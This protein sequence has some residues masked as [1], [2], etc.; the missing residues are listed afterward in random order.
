MMWHD[1]LNLTK[2]EAVARLTRDY[3]SDIAAYDM[4]HEQAMMMADELAWGIAEQFPD[5]FAKC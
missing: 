4:I 2:Q 5:K 1:H 3:E